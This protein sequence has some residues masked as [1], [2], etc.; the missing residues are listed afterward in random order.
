VQN[1]TLYSCSL[2]PISYHGDDISRLCCLVIEIPILGY[3][4]FW[5]FWRYLATCNAKS[6]VGFLLGDSDF[7]LGRRNFAPILLSYGDSHFGVF[8]FFG[9]FGGFGV[10]SYFRCKI[11]RHILAQR[12][13]FPIRAT[14]FRAYLALLSRSPFWAIWGF[15]GDLGYLATSDA[16]S[17]V[18]FLLIDPDFP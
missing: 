5:G 11:S 7:L 9:G 12:P 16:K 1:F 10:F 8:G 14:K 15:G 6:D 13:R 3:L 17:H 2:T 18:I 4:V